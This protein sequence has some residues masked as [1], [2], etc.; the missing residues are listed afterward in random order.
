MRVFPPRPSRID[1]EIDVVLGADGGALAG[2]LENIGIGGVFVAT[3]HFRP[4]GDRVTLSFTLPGR[5][6]PISLESEVRWIRGRSSAE[7]ADRSTG[8]GLRF[9]DAPADV[10]TAIQGFLVGEARIPDD[11]TPT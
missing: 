1:L 9:V 10:R 11:R 7:H 5:M 8:M 6:E 3:S 2:R 4:V